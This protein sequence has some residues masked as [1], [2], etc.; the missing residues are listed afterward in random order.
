M[1]SNN[2]DIQVFF[3][4]KS[5][6][7]TLSSCK[8]FATRSVHYQ[9]LFCL[10]SL[11]CMEN[12]THTKFLEKCVCMHSSFSFPFA[13]FSCLLYFSHSLMNLIWSSLST[14]V[15]LSKWGCF[16]FQCSVSI[17]SYTVKNIFSYFSSLLC[18]CIVDF[19]FWNTKCD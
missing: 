1:F 13:K 6:P 12:M 11:I 14:H 9:Y 17:L 5:P 10:P 18:I 4:K 3:C 7:P 15:C 19:Y 2:N 8:K 16:C